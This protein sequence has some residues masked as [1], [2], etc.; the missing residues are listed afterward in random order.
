MYGVYGNNTLSEF[1]DSDYAVDRDGQKSL[2]SY[3]YTFGEG[4]IRG[5]QSYNPL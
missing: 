4:S 3:V 5:N 1:Y 2:S